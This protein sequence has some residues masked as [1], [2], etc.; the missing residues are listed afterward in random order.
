AVPS[1]FPGMDPFIE[2]RKWNGFRAHVLAALSY[3]IVAAVRPRYVVDVEES[4]YLTTGDYEG[5]GLVFRTVPTPLRRRQ[6]YLAIRPL[7]SPEV[8]TVVEV[9]TP[10]NKA[11]GDGRHQDLPPVVQVLAS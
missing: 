1:P 5:A 4:M 9:L 7:R 11:Q 3:V 10:G 6:R 2:G 8:M